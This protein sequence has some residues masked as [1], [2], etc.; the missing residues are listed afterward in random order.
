MVSR[1]DNGRPVKKAY[2]KVYAKTLSGKEEFYKDGYTDIRGVF[3][4]ASISTDQMQRTVKFALFVKT[5]RFGSAV[6]YA[7][8]PKT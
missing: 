6:K 3:D 1:K 4:Y 8:V 5:E 2:V 7:S